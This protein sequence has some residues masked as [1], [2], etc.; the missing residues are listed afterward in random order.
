MK[1][2]ILILMLAS[3]LCF[4]QNPRSNARAF[5]DEL[6]LSEEQRPKVQAILKEQRD[7]LQA[8]RK[9]STLRDEVKSIQQ[10]TRERLAGVLT[11][12]QMKKWDESVKQRKNR[13][14]PAR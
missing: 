1:T 3:T 11:P 13:R 8:A 7:A 5:A 9:N 2:T 6:G 10:K 12:D 4:G 14:D